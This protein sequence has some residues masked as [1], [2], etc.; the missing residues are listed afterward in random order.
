[1]A[2]VVEIQVSGLKAFDGNQWRNAFRHFLF[3]IWGNKPEVTYRPKIGFT[4]VDGKHVTLRLYEDFKKPREPVYLAYAPTDRIP[5]GG[6]ELPTTPD[7]LIDAHSIMQF[8]IEGQL[9]RFL[10]N[11]TVTT[12]VIHFPGRSEHKLMFQ[13]DP[14]ER[15]FLDITTFGGTM[16]KDADEAERMFY[17]D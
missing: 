13:K 15:G 2:R 9:I 4:D 8:N 3:G 1:M 10:E 16:P 14:N 17:D 6:C 5:T 7:N 12:L 11:N